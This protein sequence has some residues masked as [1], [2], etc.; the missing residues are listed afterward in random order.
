MKTV[1]FLL[2]C[3]ITCACSPTPRIRIGNPIDVLPI[4]TLGKLSNF[5]STEDLDDVISHLDS[6]F[7]KHSQLWSTQADSAH[8][9]LLTQL[10]NTLVQLFNNDLEHIVQSAMIPIHLPDTAPF[11]VQVKLGPIFYRQSQK[12]KKGEPRTTGNQ[13]S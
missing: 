9:R 8:S 6:V 3:F 5:E 11:L 4:E 2:L 1:H 13:Q 7:K 10:N 12:T